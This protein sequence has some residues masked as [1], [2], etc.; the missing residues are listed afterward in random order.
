V[1]AYKFLA[2][3]SIGPFS[4]FHWPTPRGGRPGDWVEAPA[5]D[6]ERGVHGCRIE[7]L[8]YW[9]DE[10]LWR[11]E[12]D[13]PVVDRPLQ[14]VSSRGRLVE[15][16]AGWDAEGQ[17]RFAE[18]SAWRARDVAVA[19][20]RDTG[21]AAHADARGD[22]RP[23]RAEER[24]GRLRGSR[25]APGAPRGVPRRRGP[26]HG[27]GERGGRE[28]RGGTRRGGRRTRRGRVH[29]RARAAGAAARGC[30]APVTP[31]NVAQPPPGPQRADATG[32]ARSMDGPTAPHGPEAPTGAPPAASAGADADREVLAALRRGDERAFAALVDRHYPAMVRIARLYVASTSAAEDVAQEAWLGVLQGLAGFQGRCSLKAWIFSIV[33]NCARTRGARDKRMLPMSSLGA[34]EEDDGP[35]VAPERFLDASHPRWAGH[36]SRAPE[37]WSDA[38]LVEQETLRAVSRAIETL[39][40]AQRAVMTM[41]D[42]EGLDAEET[43][44][45]LGLSEGNQRVLLHRARSKVRKAMESFMDEGEA[46]P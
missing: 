35:S 41:R 28:L 39:P 20:L 12:L 5:G 33:A 22:G 24:R 30:P 45:C 15:R 19:A 18:A 32:D 27:R 6:V 3:G 44:Q 40:P 21:A 37:A 36:W 14:V 25:R 8:P 9:F 2:A 4:G 11:L 34:A 7:H 23:D 43:C 29:E 31:R 42:V 17:R 46:S 1:I 10:E 38:R 16:V 13:D 26:T